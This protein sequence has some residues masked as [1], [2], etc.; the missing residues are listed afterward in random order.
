[1]KKARTDRG[2][3][4]KS[5]RALPEIDFSRYRIR[6]NRFANRIRREGIE[7]LHEEPSRGSLREMPEPDLT[8]ASVRRNPYAERIRAAGITLQVGR[9]RPRRQHE[10]GPTVTRSVRLPP[11]VW[12]DLEKRAR[13][14]GVAVH[15]LLRRAIA[16]LLAA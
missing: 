11:R 14:E 5:L 9:G 12:A 2:P 10:V 16:Q 15:A 7:L 8:R 4:K 1:M 13:A 6:R 3:S